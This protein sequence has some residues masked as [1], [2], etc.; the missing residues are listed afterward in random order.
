MQCTFRGSSWT[1]AVDRVAVTNDKIPWWLWI[2]SQVMSEVIGVCVFW[3]ERKHVANMI[4]ELSVGTIVSEADV[5]FWNILH[6]TSQSLHHD[7]CVQLCSTIYTYHILTH[8]SGSEGTT[9][10]VVVVGLLVFVVQVIVVIVVLVVIVCCY[11]NYFII[12]WL[13][14]LMFMSS[15]GSSSSYKHKLNYAAFYN[16]I[17]GM[18]IKSSHAHLLYAG[19]TSD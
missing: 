11:T 17:S 7:F 12:S 18:Q 9:L 4:T 14:G 6:R 16:G 2:P 10:E 8:I 1:E 3:E 13:N 19:N 5:L 15:A